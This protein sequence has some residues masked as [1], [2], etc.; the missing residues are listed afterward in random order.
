MLLFS[1]HPQT[2]RFFLVYRA[3]AE[4]VRGGLHPIGLDNTLEHAPEEIA[5]AK[6][7]VAVA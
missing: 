4:I 6:P 2:A 1:A 3:R 5:L 7:F